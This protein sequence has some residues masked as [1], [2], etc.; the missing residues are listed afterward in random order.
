MIIITLHDD[1]N[2]TIDTTSDED[3]DPRVIAATLHQ[4][5]DAMNEAA[6]NYEVIEQPMPKAVH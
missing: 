3:D 5:A 2:F 6:D 4:V 1:D